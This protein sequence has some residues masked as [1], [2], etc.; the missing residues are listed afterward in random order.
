MTYNMLHTTAGDLHGWAG[1]LKELALNGQCKGVGFLRP[2]H[3]SMLALAL[4][5]KRGTLKLPAKLEAYACRMHVWQAIGLPPPVEVNEADGNGRFLPVEPLREKRENMDNAQKLAA[6]ART[7]GADEKTENSLG[8]S[9]SEIMENC[10]AHADVTTP[11]KG[12]ACAQ[13][14]QRGNLSQITI[15]DLGI[16]IRKSLEA[17]SALHDRL[18]I[19]NACELATEF[20]VTSKPG[21]GHAGYGLA[22]ARQLIE[23]ANGALFVY[24]QNELFA[25]VKGAS[26]AMTTEHVWPGTVVVLEWRCDQPLDS[27]KVY[28]SWPQPEGYTDDDF[29]F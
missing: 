28:A 1:Q 4:H 11:L 15:A 27:K 29:D 10:F 2:F 25:S 16:G 26:F 24:S 8:I 17:N 19:G 5:A 23:A 21:R 20:G 12:V 9:L 14:W 13:S 7:Y 22:L 3:M 6:I 18:W